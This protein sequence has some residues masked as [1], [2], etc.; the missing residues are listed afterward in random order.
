MPDEVAGETVKAFVSLK[1]GYQPDEALRRELMGQARKR[2]G[3]RWRRAISS[4]AKTCRVPAV[5]RS[6]ADCCAPASSAFPKATPL[7]WRAPGNEQAKRFPQ[8]PDIEGTCT[9]SAARHAARTPFR[10][11][12]RAAV[13]AGKDSW[14]S[15]CLH[16][17][18]SGGRRRHVQHRGRRGG[19][20]R[21]PGTWPCPAQGA[22][23]WTG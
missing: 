22:W 7:H 4:S 14:L 10:G 15:A 21:L 8:T 3:L 13:H 5:A 1:P 23:P 17:P 2:L 12:L 20:G 9:G 18:G 6:C 19:G 11:T 16:R